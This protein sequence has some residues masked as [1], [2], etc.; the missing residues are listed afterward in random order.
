MS[1]DNNAPADDVVARLRNPQ[2][3]GRDLGYGGTP[4]FTDSDIRALLKTAKEAAAE[5]DQLRAERDAAV[6]NA[7]VATETQNELTREMFAAIDRAEKAEADLNKYAWERDK[8]R[9]ER[10]QAERRAEEFWTERLEGARGRIRELE[11][12]LRLALPYVER[13][14]AAEHSMDGFTIVAGEP[15]AHRNPARSDD[16]LEAIRALIERNSK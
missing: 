4:F 11:D 1:T 6:A 8:A 9:E 2:M 16:D 13:Q 12:G 3:S 15:V 10:D 14:N 5:I 7:D